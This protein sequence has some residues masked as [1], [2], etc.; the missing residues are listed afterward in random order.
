MVPL[1]VLLPLPPLILRLVLA[2]RGVAA[3]VLL[4]LLVFLLL[5]GRQLVQEGPVL[6]GQW[7]GVKPEIA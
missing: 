6:L 1:L 7:P 5:L 3:A 4:V 2:C